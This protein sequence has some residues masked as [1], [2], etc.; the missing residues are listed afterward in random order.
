MHQQHNL[1]ILMLYMAQVWGSSSNLLP[2]TA[3]NTNLGNYMQQLVVE[4]VNVSATTTLSVSDAGTPI[5]VDLL[6]MRLP[7]VPVLDYNSGGADA[8]GVQVQAE[9]RW[10]GAAR[11][12]VHMPSLVRRWYTVLLV[13]F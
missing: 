6:S 1:T 7:I 4:W 2:P 10:E 13:D 12:T 3:A 5:R 9:G 8:N 11:I